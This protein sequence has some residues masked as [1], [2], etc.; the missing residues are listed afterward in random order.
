[1]QAAATKF[2]EI[3]YGVSVFGS[4]RVRPDSPYYTLAHELGERLAKA[5]ITVIAGGGPGIMEAVNRGAFEAGGKSVGLNIRL[6][7]ETHNNAYQTHSLH[8]KHFFSRKATFFSHSIGYIILPGGFGT[9]DELFEIF[10]LVQTCK[11]A[12]VPIILV[13]ST[14]WAGLIA[15]IESQTLAAGFISLRDLSL[16]RICDDVDSIIREIE[17][18]CIGDVEHT[19]CAV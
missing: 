7:R 12:P 2:L 19:D 3:G 13:G 14:Y 18:S 16:F 10:T 11:T 1:M 9:L 17:A 8:F 4:A 5:G 6:P 15:W